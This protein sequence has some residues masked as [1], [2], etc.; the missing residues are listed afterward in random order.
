MSHWFTLGNAAPAQNAR[1]QKADM[2]ESGLTPAVSKQS[3]LPRTLNR[4]ESE[5]QTSS[6]DMPLRTRAC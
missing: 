2:A 5:W 1:F 4:R 3:G 6:F